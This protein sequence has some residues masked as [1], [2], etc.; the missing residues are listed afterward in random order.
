MQVCFLI[1]PR[2]PCAVRGVTSGGAVLRVRV[3]LWE[4]AGPTLIQVAATSHYEKCSGKQE[5]E[6]GQCHLSSSDSSGL[7]LNS[8]SLFS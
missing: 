8:G 1:I 7:A 6:T 4:V 2:Q 3:L 5:R